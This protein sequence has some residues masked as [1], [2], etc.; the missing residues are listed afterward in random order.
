M[1]LETQK[2]TDEI[3]LFHD[4]ITNFRQAGLKRL[5][6]RKWSPGRSLPTPGGKEET[7]TC[8]WIEDLRGE[9]RGRR[10]GREVFIA[11]GDE[12]RQGVDM[13]GVLHHR[14]F[15]GLSGGRERS[16]TNCKN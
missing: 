8:L 16:K 4:L 14:D 11:V 12:G 13:V 10:A 3:Q 2:K 5:K 9:V 6:G 1:T 7:F 15:I